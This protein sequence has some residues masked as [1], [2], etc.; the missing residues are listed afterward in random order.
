MD[1]F[2]GR[3][4]RI[5]LRVAVVLLGCLSLALIWPFLARE[6][7][8][9]LTFG[10]GA[11]AA[12]LALTAAVVGV[13]ARSL[14]ALAAAV[15]VLVAAGARAGAALEYDVP[16][17]VS[18]GAAGVAALAVVLL[19]LAAR[20]S[21]QV[22][23]DAGLIA[24]A[25]VGATYL[26]EREPGSVVVGAA[27]VVGVAFSVGLLGLRPVGSRRTSLLAAGLSVGAL[28]TALL[29]D[30]DAVTALWWV[31]LALALPAVFV[32]EQGEV[33]APRDLT[34]AVV[35]AAT[36]L[37]GGLAATGVIDSSL[38]VCWSILGVVAA[39]VG[40]GALRDRNVIGELHA[41]RTRDQVTGLGNREAFRDAL[42]VHLR[43]DAEPSL[44]VVFD[45]HGFKH[46]NDAFG[47]LAGDGVLRHLAERLRAAT[48]PA[49]AFRLRGDEFA[50]ISDF[51]EGRAEA[52]LDRAESAL[53]VR[54]DGF[55][56]GAHVGAVVIP[57]ETTDAGEAMRIVD[58]R[59]LIQ[60]R[61]S[62]SDNRWDDLDR[63]IDE[64]RGSVN[65]AAD[66]GAADLA[67]LA[68]AVGA[69][70]DL[71]NDQLLDLARAAS[72][73]N[74]GRVAVPTTASGAVAPGRGGEVDRNRHLIGERLLASAPDMRQ[75]ATIVRSAAE[76]WDGSGGPDGLEGAAIP[77]G[78][79]ILAVCEA[80]RSARVIRRDGEEDP[81]QS[82]HG[83]ASDAGARFDPWVIAGLRSALERGTST[84]AD[85]GQILP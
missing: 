15:A 4:K 79:R 48:W 62:G 18:V 70:L 40:Y 46:Y 43:G 68:L 30:P 12:L 80:Y 1:H 76:H 17:L 25:A 9:L 35:A 67:A 33:S 71:T 26:V 13:G 72:L 27:V 14:P 45:L 75:A 44:L 10:I 21:T 59:I 42:E 31:A 54:G 85:G 49:R 5:E 57:D 37:A 77:V 16:A 51:G 74:L 53:T 22:T 41:D 52:V 47:E 2:P 3:G 56:I 69:Q 24:A 50:V 66:S 11:Q 82:L 60:R 39:R 58:Q 7:D 23:L 32:S 78:S 55:A 6:E 19:F 64:A 36:L 20:P 65:A 63:H 34:V 81:L 84:G 8:A 61:T 28:A 29:A 38:I 83:I 73:H